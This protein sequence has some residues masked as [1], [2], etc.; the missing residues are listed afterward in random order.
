VKFATALSA[1]KSAHPP[2]ELEPVSLSQIC[3]P[4][5]SPVFPT[6]DEKS[7]RKKLHVVISLARALQA[8]IKDSFSSSRVLA[9]LLV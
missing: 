5:R 3:F 4:S 7:G 1:R 2:V 6:F 8:E 9:D